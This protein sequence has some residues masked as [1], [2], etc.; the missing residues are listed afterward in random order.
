MLYRFLLLGLIGCGESKTTDTADD[1]DI[2]SADLDNGQ[3]LHD[4]VCQACH[5]S[6]PAMA[7][8]TADLSNTQLQSVIVDGV[9]SMPPQASLSDQDV[10]DVIGYLREIY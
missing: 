8:N 9:G 2:G 5:S 10:I 4:T 1:L 7:D 6:N 3:T